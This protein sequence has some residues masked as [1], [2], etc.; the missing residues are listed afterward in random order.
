M[1]RHKEAIS[2]AKQL[3]DNVELQR[4]LTH[5]QSGHRLLAEAYE[6]VGEYALALKHHRDFK[7]ISDSIY[8]R[9]KLEEITENDARFNRVE[10]ESKIALLNSENQ[11]NSALL[12]QKNRTI[13][14]GGASLVLITLLSFFLYRLLSKV[15]NQK[16]ML[17][18]ALKDKD[19]LIK[20]IHHRV[21][22]NLQLVSSLLSLQSKSID[23]PT[24]S[25]AIAEGKAR[26]RSM[27]LIHQD[28]YQRDNLTGVNVNSYLD[29]LCNELFASYKVDNE[30]VKLNL[31]IIDITLDV[32]TVIPMGLIINELITNSLKYA[33][34]NNRKGNLSISLQQIKDELHLSVSDDGVGYSASENTSKKSFGSTLIRALSKQLDGTLKIDHEKGTKVSMVFKKFVI[35]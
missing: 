6:S 9:D 12:D 35:S 31:D 27:A 19:L 34:P 20:E 3:F 24:V 26:V 16:E 5:Q 29:D 7:M 18:N 15:S 23:D 32:D 2:E 13:A 33:F 22:N 8:N 21:K 28:L 14:I 25:D 10:Q 17:S 11:S 1:G 30:H 4:S